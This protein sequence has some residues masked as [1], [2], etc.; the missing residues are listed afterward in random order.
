MYIC[1]YSVPEYEAKRLWR[2]AEYA[3]INVGNGI[4]TTKFLMP[5]DHGCKRHDMSDGLADAK[6]RFSDAFG[7]LCSVH[8]DIVWRVCV[9]DEAITQYEIKNGWRKSLGVPMLESALE[10]LVMHYRDVERERRNDMR[11]L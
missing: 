7:C 3:S 8:K 2:G 10:Y 5:I 6:K 4:D 9:C 11:F 1:D